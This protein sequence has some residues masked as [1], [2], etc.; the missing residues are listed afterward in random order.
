MK[1]LVLGGAGMMG[2]GT[3]RD[4]LSDLSANDHEVIA[5]D[6]SREALDRLPDHPRLRKVA[7]DAALGHS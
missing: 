1:I 2:S 5:S 7:G 6:F 4:L 3:I